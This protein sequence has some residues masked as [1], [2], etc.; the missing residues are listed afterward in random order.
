[1]PALFLE[2]WIVDNFIADS[3]GCKNILIISLSKEYLTASKTSMH[4]QRLDEL[5]FC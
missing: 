5:I 4:L 1:M 3:R 2:L